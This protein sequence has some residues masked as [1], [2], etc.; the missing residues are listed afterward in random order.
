MPLVP[1]KP[2]LEAWTEHFKRTESDKNVV[3]LKSSL[4]KPEAV[5]E[6]VKVTV[7]SPTEQTVER[8]KVLVKNE[9]KKSRKRKNPF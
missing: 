4:K 1:Y 8:A 5:A 7:V 2:D 9:A 3:P 6:Q